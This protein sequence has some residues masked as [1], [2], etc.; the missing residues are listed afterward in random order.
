MLVN[1]AVALASVHK[2]VFRWQ[3]SDVALV[4]HTNFSTY[5]TLSS[6]LD[7]LGKLVQSL[8]QRSS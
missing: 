6:A 7:V 1:W 5:V 2:R 3:S 8:Y 4:V